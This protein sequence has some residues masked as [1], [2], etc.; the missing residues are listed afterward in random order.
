MRARSDDEQLTIGQCS[1]V[2]GQ[3]DSFVGFECA[4]E[5]E[6]LGSLGGRFWVRRGEVVCS[7][8]RMDDG[9]V[10]MVVFFDLVGGVGRVGDEV[11]DAIGRGLVPPAQGG[12]G[13]PEPDRS[14]RPDE[15]V[16]VVE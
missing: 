10:S 11:G 2:D 1:R 4:D 15:S 13:D 7:D 6:S 3:V 8:G 5:Q 16:C 9:R 12:G 14:E